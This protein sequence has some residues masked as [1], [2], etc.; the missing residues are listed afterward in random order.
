MNYDNIEV[1]E[2]CIQRGGSIV[3]NIGQYVID[4]FDYYLGSFTI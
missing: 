2:I 1:R 4:Q 3:G